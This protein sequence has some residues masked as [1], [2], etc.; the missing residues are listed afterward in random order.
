MK[1]QSSSFWSV[2]SGIRKKAVAGTCP[3]RRNAPYAVT[4]WLLSTEANHPLILTG[5]PLFM[6]QNH[7]KP[8]V[9]QAMGKRSSK[10]KN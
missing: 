2:G 1:N 9:S 4:C 6:T 5:M 3:N 10:E 8:F 7:P